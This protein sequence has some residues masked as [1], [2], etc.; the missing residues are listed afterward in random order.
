[1]EPK[2]D[3]NPPPVD[4]ELGTYYRL[5]TVNRWLFDLEVDEGDKLAT[6][7]DAA[8]DNVWADKKEESDQMF[9]TFNDRYGSEVRV[10][11]AHIEVFYYSSPE[12]RA[13]EVEADRKEQRWK[14]STK[15]WDSE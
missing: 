8:R 6:V 5:S 10:R 14:K 12:T 7:L 11:M 4:D 13:R 1:M 15:E 3:R 9:V 2:G